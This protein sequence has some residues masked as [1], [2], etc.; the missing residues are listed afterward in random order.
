MLLPVF[1]I[2]DLHSYLPLH[3]LLEAL[4]IAAA[5]MIFTVGW[6]SFGHIR[7]AHLQLL[8]CAFFAAATLDFAQTLSYPGMP[9]VIANNGL[10][11][12]MNF[13]LPARFITALALLTAAGLPA[14]IILTHHQRAALLMTTMLFIGILLLMGFVFPETAPQSFTTNTLNVQEITAFKLG[15]ESLV[16]LFQGTALVLLIRNW[17]RKRDGFHALLAS[18]LLILLLGEFSLMQHFI[19]AD[20]NNLLGHIYKAWGVSLVFWAV[21][22]EAMTE[23]IFADLNNLLGHIYKAWGVSLVFWA[24][25]AEAMTEPYKRLRQSEQQ[26]TASEAQTKALLQENRILLDNAFVGIFFVKDRRFIRVNR[27]A[28]LLFGYAH[29]EM[30]DVSTEIIYPNYAEFLALGQRA[31]STINRGELFNGEVELKRKDGTCFWGLMRAQAL[32]PNQIGEGSIWII[33]D[34]TERRAT[35]QALEDAA[36]LYRAIFESRHLI[37]IL[38]D[39]NNGRILDANQAAAEFYGQSRTMLR[40]SYA[41][42]FSVTPR[43][44]LQKL[45]ATISTESTALITT[46]TAW[47]RRAN[48]ELCEVEIHIDQLIRTHQHLLLA[49]IL[50]LTDRK[51]AETALRDSEERHRSA[52]AAL[53]E[54]VAV[55]NCEGTLITSNPAAA[56]I[57]GLFPTEYQERAIDDGQWRIIRA[58]GSVFRSTEWPSVVTLR[59]GIVQRD[60]EMGIVKPDHSI[61]WLLVNSEPIRNME[62]GAVQ[63]V[64]VSFADITERKRNEA[65]LAHSEARFRILF[66]KSKVIKLL[67]DP[68]S[69]EIVDANNA[70]SDYYGYSI[71]QLCSMKIYDINILSPEQLAQEMLLAQQEQRSVFHFQHR[72]ANGE[73]REVEVHSSPLHLEDRLLLHSVIH[74]ITDRRRAEAALRLSLEEIQR[75]DAQMMTLNR[76]N[77]WLMSCEK[78]SEAYAVVERGARQLFAGYNG[79]LAIRDDHQPTQLNCVATWGENHG[80]PSQFLFDDCWAVRR[81]ECHAVID[82]S[83]VTQCHHFTH[84]PPRSYFCASL[85]VRGETLGLLH[86]NT[87]ETLT[88]AQCRELQTLLMTVSEAIKLSLANIQLQERLREQA[89]RDRLTGL[90]NRRYLDETL[91]RELNRCQRRGESLAVAMLDVDHFKRFNDSYGHDA[92][93]AVL[94]AIGQLLRDTVRASD[95]ACRYGGEELTLVLPN[96]DLKNAQKCLEKLRSAIMQLRVLHQGGEL[97]AITVSIGVAV[98]NELGV[99]ATALLKQA[100]AA[101]YRA[102]E[103][104]RNRVV[105]A[106]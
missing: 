62:S 97:P 40:Q 25:Y 13:W 83:S 45:F 50:D 95:L 100:D 73:V 66:T 33:E 37:K 22:A 78:R 9:D 38:I 5:L 18:G 90:F 44:V 106:G 84:S 89:M 64:A 74:D 99:S 14:Q 27:G 104:G 10:T 20:L 77:E 12:A 7:S 2:E 98:T 23:F 54:G 52:L 4:S 101:L 48:G 15:A 43:E 55:Y 57:L 71:A 56:R 41:W 17:R 81:G 102:K 26:L 87:M 1:V 58:D 34:A 36:G 31:Y 49:T 16:M 11:Q 70:A 29:G 8:A 69:G 6:F 68:L 85:S 72:L 46:K 63:A 28:E 32:I 67:I 88:T 80:L 65:A 79:G 35:R 105:A 94:Q 76:L 3:N 51:A 93:D 24:V 30:N 21:Y 86:L 59:T 47:H 96:T 92:G 103:G 61:T 19:F 53:A 42:D 60:I 82:D 75:H 91:P 39:P